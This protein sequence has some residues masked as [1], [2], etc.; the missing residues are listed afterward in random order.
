M[1]AKYSLTAA[2]KKIVTKIK[3][4][5]GTPSEDDTILETSFSK[6]DYATAFSENFDL[7]NMDKFVL[8]RVIDDNKDGLTT[9][10]KTYYKLEDYFYN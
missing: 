2:Q 8:K 10:G 6:K 5:Y 3:E 4:A 9:D 7:A 1:Y